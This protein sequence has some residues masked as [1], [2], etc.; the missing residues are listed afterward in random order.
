MRERDHR[1]RPEHDGAALLVDLEEGFAFEPEGT[2]GFS[3]KGHSPVWA[4]GNYASH[5]NGSI[6]R[7]AP[8]GQTARVSNCHLTAWPMIR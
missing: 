6:R 5:A 4:H 2:P 3:R 7:P 1:D 8:H